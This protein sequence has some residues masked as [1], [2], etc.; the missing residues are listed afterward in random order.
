LALL[1]RSPR[2]DFDLCRRQRLCQSLLLSQERLTLF[3]P[4][5]DAEL[6]DTWHVSGL[7][8][9]ASDTYVVKDLFVPL[10]HT[11]SRDSATT[12]LSRCTDRWAIRAVKRGS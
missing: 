3:F 5:Q 6:R 10:A 9:T 11:T 12:R 1:R 7:R 4:A 2:I 8:G